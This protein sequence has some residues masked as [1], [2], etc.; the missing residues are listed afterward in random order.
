MIQVSVQRGNE[1]KTCS[2]MPSV[3]NNAG[4]VRLRVSGL[5]ALSM[6]RICKLGKA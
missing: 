1:T 3:G 5:G 2:G 6:P 4:R